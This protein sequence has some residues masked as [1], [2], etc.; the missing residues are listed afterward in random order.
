MNWQKYRFIWLLAR[1]D[2]LEDRVISVIVVAMLAFSYLNLTFFPAFINGLSDSF[3]SDLIETQTGHV[4]IQP[5]EGRY[6][7]NAE[8]LVD[9]ASR[10]EDVVLVEKRLSF[11]GRLAFQD[12]SVSAQF[13]GTSALGDAIYTSRMQRDGDTTVLGQTLAQEGETFGLDGLGVVPGRMV[14]ATVGGRRMRLEVTGTIGQPGASSLTRQAFIPYTTAADLLGVRDAASAI[15]VII[16]DREDAAVV[17]RQLLR[18]NTR[19]EIKTW[20]ERSNVAESFNQTFAIVVAVISLVGVIIALTSIGVVIFINTNKRAREMG[21]LK[22]IGTE[23]GDVMKIFVLE[24]LLFGTVGIALGNVLMVGIDA[25]LNAA[26]I[27]TPIGPLRTAVTTSL[28]VSRS[29]WML[30]A[31]LVAGFLPAYLMSRRGI[32]ETIEAR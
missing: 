10:L 30:V 15:H 2:L 22:A 27:H 6:L 24:A 8:A 7:R 12:E 9:T 1:R 16:E 18:L 29:A 5:E 21:I 13:V 14:T 20:R 23:S 4:S 25:Y 28:L 19:G 32:I 26:P 11:T 3:T 31:S 17:K